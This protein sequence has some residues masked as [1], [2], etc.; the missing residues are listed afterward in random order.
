MKSLH[1]LNGL[2][3][4]SISRKPCVATIGNFDGV[5]RGHEMVIQTLLDAAAAKKLPSTV[6]TFQP[7]ALVRYL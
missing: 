7:L 5:H 2:E 3:A 1:V 4:L 6:V